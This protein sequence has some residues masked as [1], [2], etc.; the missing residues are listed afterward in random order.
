MGISDHTVF[1]Q[2]CIKFCIPFPPGP[3]GGGII[4]KLIWR[5]FKIGRKEGKKYREK[6]RKRGETDGNKGEKE[7]KKLKG[8]KNRKGS[9]REIIM[10]KSCVCG[11]N[12]K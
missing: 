6:G 9:K 4:S 1:I 8:Q 10:T 12:G 7:E 5:L 2:G 3:G 11:K